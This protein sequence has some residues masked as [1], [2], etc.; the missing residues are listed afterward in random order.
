MEENKKTLIMAGAA[1]VLAVV[2]FF[3]APGRIT[4][5]AF[6]DQGESFFKDFT[7]PNAA[8]VLE[9]IE[10]D[11]ESG[12][13]K[14]FKVVNNNGIWT[15]PSHH[16]HPAD[17]A[18]R[19]AQ[20]A[21]G[22]I[23][24]KKDDFRSDNVS[25]HESL[26]VID[27]LDETA[28]LVGRGQRITLKDG[29]GKVLAD[30]IV[31]REV[32]GRPGFRFVR[33]PDQ[34][35][36]YAVRME[37]DIST[38]FEDWIETD[39]LLVAKSDITRIE[40]KDYSINERSRSVDQRDNVILTLNDQTWQANRMGN[41]QVDSATIEAFLSTLDE[42][43]IVGVRPKPEGLAQDL[44]DAGSAVSQVDARSL[45]SKGYFFARD[46][47][48]LSNEGELNFQMKAGVTYTLRFGE[49]VYGTGDAVTSG[50]GDRNQ[51]EG[52]A[53]NRYLFVTTEFD[54]SAFPEPAK[55]ANTDFQNKPDSSLT[56]RDRTNKDR[57][58]AHKQWL[59][60]VDDGRNH[61]DR[62]NH[63]FAKWYYVISAESFEK[64]HLTRSDLLVNK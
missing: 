40:L 30:F 35:R 18:D 22:V 53:E 25:D 28:G 57:D 16:D 56:D 1:V 24:I 26:G 43:T 42:L 41:K 9:V 14:P 31:G 21:A 52:P 49:V 3:M 7:D 45:Q 8:A 44:I 63:R 48:L 4:P 59:R 5:D 15:I 2:A 33:V 27:P 32:E 17:G 34:K 61:A 38:K 6:L 46:G 11:E 64:L 20:T 51:Q 39:L 13:T 58:Q 10:Y 50:T 62:L 55:P 37:I 29:G 19:L 47:R 23:G 36:V 60:D 12:A 54:Q